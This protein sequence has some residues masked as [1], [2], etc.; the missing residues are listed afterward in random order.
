MTTRT[1]IDVQAGTLSMEFDLIDELVEEHFQLDTC[2]DDIS[3][4]V[5]YPEVFDCLGFTTD[6]ADYPKPPNDLSSSSPPPIE[7]KPLP[8]HLKYAY[9]GNDQQFPVVI[10]NNL[11]REHKPL[12]LH[13]YNFNGGGSLTYKATTKK[14]ESDHPRRG[15][16]G[17]N[18]AAC[19]RDH[20][21]HLE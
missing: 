9:L 13:A 20:L 3:N 12:H 4:F 11:H 7:L 16:E 14:A 10:A 8:S 19:H 17:S 1:K 18:K 6:E 21:S 15:Q 2:S 5:G